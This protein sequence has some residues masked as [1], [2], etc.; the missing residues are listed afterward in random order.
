MRKVFQ[1]DP[2]KHNLFDDVHEL[3]RF[4]RWLVFGFFFEHNGQFLDVNFI[5]KNPLPVLRIVIM[6]SEVYAKSN[7]VL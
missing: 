4:D 7:E 6:Y 1:V 3:V 5:G 2:V